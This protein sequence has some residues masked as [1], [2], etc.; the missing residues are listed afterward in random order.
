MSLP[1]DVEDAM[2]DIALVFHWPPGAMD[3][4]SIDELVRW[5]EKARERFEAQQAALQP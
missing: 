3:G 5:R 2:A 4:M 1:E